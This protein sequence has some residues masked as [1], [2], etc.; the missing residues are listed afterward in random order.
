MGGSI[1][2]SL[3]FL[4][5]LISKNYLQSNY[6]FINTL[7]VNI[8]GS[9]LI[10]YIISIIGYKNY[11]QEFL[12]YFI[13]V[14]ILGSFTTFSAFSYETIELLTNKKYFIAFF[15]IILSLSLCLLFTFL[16]LNLNKA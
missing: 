1:G 10:G 11:S 8:I 6:L 5:Y 9:F 14:G 3:R 16:G 13:I 12:R 4:F 2:A 15:Y 7:L